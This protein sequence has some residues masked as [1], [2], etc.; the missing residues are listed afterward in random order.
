MSQV[1]GISSNILSL[2]YQNRL[3]SAKQKIAGSTTIASDPLDELVQAGTITQDQEDS[4]KSSLQSSAQTQKATDSLLLK[5][6]PEDTSSILQQLLNSDTATQDQQEKIQSEFQSLMKMQQAQAAY[7][8]TGKS[9]DALDSLLSPTQSGDATSD[10]LM[11]LLSSLNGDT[12]DDEDSVGND[13][14]SLLKMQ[15]AQEAYS[16][17]SRTTNPLGSLVQS[18]AISQDQE[19]AV[20]QAIQKSVGSQLDVAL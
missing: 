18:G 1:S 7:N 13:F 15:Q 14:T 5:G 3:A 11:Q 6:L 16:L 2:Y 20:Y 17:G 8:F 19:N 10:P 12:Q 4:I 9:S